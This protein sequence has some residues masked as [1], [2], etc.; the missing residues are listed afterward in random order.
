MSW[1][2]MTM[3]SKTPFF[4]KTVA[5]QGLKRTLPLWLTHAVVWAMAMP[6]LMTNIYP[7]TGMLGIG[8]YILMTVHIGGPL[9]AAFFSM[10][11]SEL[12]CNY[13]YSARSVS[14]YHS[15]PVRRSALFRTNLLVGLG[16]LLVPAALI[17]LVTWL[18]LTALGARDL[19]PTLLRWFAAYA[20]YVIF[21]TGF[22]LLCAHVT[23]HVGIGT[24]IYAILNFAAVALELCVRFILS[25]FLYGVRVRTELIG[26]TRF[27][28]PLV[29]IYYDHGVLLQDGA[30]I[31]TGGSYRLGLLAAGVVMTLLAWLLYRVRR[32]ESA[33]EIVSEPALR[34]VFKYCMTAGFAFIVGVILY[35]IT[36][37][38]RDEQTPASLLW[39]TVCMLAGGAIG[40]FVSEMML[41]KSLRVFKRSLRGFAAAA[42]AIVLFCAA[43]GFDFFGVERRVPNLDD[44]K[45]VT[46]EL[47]GVAA[48][49]TAEIR[50]GDPWLSDVTDM[51]RAIIRNKDEDRSR[52]SRTE[53]ND[54]SQ[55]WWDG[56]TVTLEYE[57][58]NG[59]KLIRAYTL[60]AWHWV[61]PDEDADVE[62][63]VSSEYVDTVAALCAYPE[64][65]ERAYPMFWGE[66]QWY[67]TTG[68]VWQ[69]AATGDWKQ[70]NEEGFKKAAEALKQDLL[71][72]RLHGWR[73]T[74]E[75]NGDIIEVTLG[76][77]KNETGREG[78]FYDV[79]F[80]VTPEAGRTW[81]VLT[82][83]TNYCDELKDV[84]LSDPEAFGQAYPMLA[85]PDGW[86]C[87]GASVISWK[88]AWTLS[89]SV[90]DTLTEQLPGALAQGDVLPWD[91]DMVR[92]E[93]QARLTLTYCDQA[94]QETAERSFMIFEG[95]P[96][97]DLITD[98]ENIAG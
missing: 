93:Q 29:K 49:D 35:F 42:A 34:P 2:V 39:F 23:G 27:L 4:D 62:Q 67:Q 5:R 3:I 25:M 8:Y 96:L 7:H 72:G 78:D 38:I 89:E 21:F 74:R 75:D 88:S 53:V 83:M 18:M 87:T 65:I 11:M 12:L 59:S 61:R 33:G 19:V 44:I 31:Y 45:S 46:V 40:Y 80:A 90:Y 81:A 55:S 37:F 57:L 68:E 64:V 9:M 79:H 50:A 86:T 63:D 48:F 20:E 70:L 82:D 28:S 69:S 52:L 1:E 6:V 92:S 14:F 94:A 41:R 77:I 15:L 54:G 84:D 32:S 43:I 76:Y 95:S 26:V 16:A 24:L 73:N 85:H 60:P 97:W 30:R 58:T 22:S 13:L 17:G 91:Y 51:H 56:Q 66:G 10:M 71:E 36:Y 47:Y 98:E